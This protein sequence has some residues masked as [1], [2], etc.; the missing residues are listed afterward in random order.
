M[1]SITE[2]I[3]KI[4]ITN[5]PIFISPAIELDKKVYDPNFTQQEKKQLRAIFRLLLNEYL[6]NFFKWQPEQKVR[7]A[8]NKIPH[9]VFIVCRLKLG[10]YVGKYY[11]PTL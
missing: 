3:K 2:I 1:A 6:V 10:T 5:F 8:V 11:I 7:D 4:D 9:K